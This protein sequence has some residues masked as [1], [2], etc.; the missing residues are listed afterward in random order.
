MHFLGGAFSAM[1]F[2]WFYF[3]SGYF[4][5]ENR[6]F[7]NFF[8]VSMVGLTFIAFAWEIYELLIGEAKFAG[9]N[10]AYDT[11]LDFVMDYLGGITSCMYAYMKE[12]DTIKK[13]LTKIADGRF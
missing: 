12:I 9:D 5:P 10:Y 11:V 6:N 13:E 1:F 2:I 8:V 4:K 7:K 3:F